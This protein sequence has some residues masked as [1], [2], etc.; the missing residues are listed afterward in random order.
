MS[1]NPA[2]AFF[3]KNGPLKTEIQV[4]SWSMSRRGK[5]A[6][7]NNILFILGFFQLSKICDVMLLILCN[8]ITVNFIFIH[9]NDISYEKF[10]LY[11]F[12]TQIIVQ[13]ILFCCFQLFGHMGTSTHWT[14]QKIFG[15]KPSRS[16]PVIQLN[17]VECL[18]AADNCFSHVALCN[19]WLKWSHYHLMLPYFEPFFREPQLNIYNT[20]TAKKA[21]FEC[22]MQ[23]HLFLVW[24]VLVKEQQH[25]L[26]LKC[27]FL[28]VQ[29]QMWVLWCV[30]LVEATEVCCLLIGIL[31]QPSRSFTGGLLEH[32]PTPS[33]DLSTENDIISLIRL[34][35]NQYYRKVWDSDL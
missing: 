3:C 18:L 32:K 28:S 22:V 24:F 16:E 30:Y 7:T 13:K 11:I 12:Q 10:V 1:D 9:F 15:F 34:D 19:H 33:E 35:V 17:C 14:A 31:L 8:G 2:E 4:A 20:W 27:V 23:T 21:F 29:Q 5:A 25:K 6:L 26:T